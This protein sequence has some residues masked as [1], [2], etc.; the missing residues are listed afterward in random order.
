MSSEKDAI[1]E[2]FFYLRLGGPELICGRCARIA[3]AGQKSGCSVA[4]ARLAEGKI[5]NNKGKIQQKVNKG[6]TTLC[7]C[8]TLDS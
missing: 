1:S 6:Q 8:L 4:A 2:N 7:L 3:L 5:E